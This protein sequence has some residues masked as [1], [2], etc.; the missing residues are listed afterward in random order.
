MMVS[1]NK[2]LGKLFDQIE[3]VTTMSVVLEE[4]GV[5]AVK[6]KRWTGLD[7]RYQLQDVLGAG[8]YG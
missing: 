1:S 8:A 5:F 3:I 2:P 4:D 7:E 6:G